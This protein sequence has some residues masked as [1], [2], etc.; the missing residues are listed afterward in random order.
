MLIDKMLQFLL[1]KIRIKLLLLSFQLLI[2]LK[3]TLK[4]ELR[5]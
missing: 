3:K 4:Q 5:A 1:K 2:E